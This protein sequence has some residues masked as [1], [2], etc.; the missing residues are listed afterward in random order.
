MQ[1]L[2]KYV[3]GVAAKSNVEKRQVGC[4]IVDQN[5]QIIAE[6]FNTEEV[7]DNVGMTGQNVHA[8]EA[9]CV[10]LQNAK[11][12]VGPVTAYVTHQPCPNCAKVLKDHG[13]H[14]VKVVEAFMKFDGDKV[15]Y[16]L[17]DGKF[18]RKFLLKVPVSVDEF[19]GLFLKGHLYN[20]TED[21][22]LKVN[23]MRPIVS[24]ICAAMAG[25]TEAYAE[26]IVA[27]VL[28]F[29]ARKYKAYNWKNCTDTGRYLAAAH[30]HLNSIL[31]GEELDPETDLPHIAHV[32]CNLMFLFTLG[33][34]YD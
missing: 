14:K 15:R 32:L 23:S 21:A 29:G 34:N 8:E 5:E 22:E 26:E 9:A 1:D 13:I 3:L 11:G 30:R 33:L 2:T 17:I 18:G 27:K 4:I 16:D 10:D 25:M 31:C 20:I 19:D 28:T 6:G 24:A 7:C 12:V